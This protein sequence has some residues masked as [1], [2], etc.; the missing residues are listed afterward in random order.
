MIFC[1]RLEFK[2]RVVVGETMVA[3]HEAPSLANDY[4][5]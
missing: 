1:A 3:M 2:T 5:L 4:S